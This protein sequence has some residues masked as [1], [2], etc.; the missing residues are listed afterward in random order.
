MRKQ[1]SK[2]DIGDVRICLY[3]YSIES[4]IDKDKD[5]RRF[6]IIIKGIKNLKESVVKTTDV[7]GISNLIFDIT[8]D[9]VE[10]MSSVNN[11]KKEK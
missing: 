7:L 6:S 4:D 3:E 8:K 9:V 10:I 1:L 2:H 5:F 11:P